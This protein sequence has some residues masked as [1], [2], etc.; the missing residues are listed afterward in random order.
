MT[1]SEQVPPQ[2]LCDTMQERQG[3][4]NLR[5]LLVHVMEVLLSPHAAFSNIALQ[6][7]SMSLLKRSGTT[8][9]D[10]QSLADVQLL[11]WLLSAQ[12]HAYIFLCLISLNT[13]NICKY[14]CQASLKLHK[15]AASELGQE[16][17]TTATPSH[18][19]HPCCHR[20]L[21]PL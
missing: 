8:F 16:C 18:R 1:K 20:I 4:L 7:S 11:S 9:S 3:Q 2:S 17:D 6:D 15:H 12:V 19:P 14:R 10:G 5:A 13:W 21:E